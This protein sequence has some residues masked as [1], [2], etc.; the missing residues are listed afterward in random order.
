VPS[1]QGSRLPRLPA[2][3]I[4]AQRIANPQDTHRRP[5]LQIG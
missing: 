3:Y 4:R 1:V 5:S 2:C